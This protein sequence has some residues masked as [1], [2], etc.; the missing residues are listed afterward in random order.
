APGKCFRLYSVD[1]YEGMNEDIVPEILRCNLGSVIL[2]LKA[3]GV[4]DVTNSRFMLMVG[5][6]ENLYALG[7]LNDDS[8]LSDLGRS[9]AEFPLDPLFS[10]VIINSKV[11]KYLHTNIVIKYSKNMN[12]T[13]E[14]LTIVAMLSVEN[15][16]FAPMDKREDA[17]EAKKKFI[18]HDGDHLTLLNVWDGYKAVN[19]D[20]DWCTQ[21]F[22]NGRA[23][24]QVQVPTIYDFKFHV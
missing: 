19:G 21:N 2:L 5:A 4:E 7:A 13:S 11:V 9:M 12:C 14:I 20:R 8:T 17:S 15:V 6:L 3:S 24:R 18:N 16:F 1:G 10:K 23:M 22:I